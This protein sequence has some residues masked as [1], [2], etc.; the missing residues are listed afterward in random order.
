MK[1]FN[2]S[3]KLLLLWTRNHN[4]PLSYNE[5]VMAM[6]LTKKE[7]SLL[8]ETLQALQTEGLIQKKSR[9]FNLIEA[10]QAPPEPESNGK[11]NPKLLE[12]TFDA[13]PL[14]R[15]QSFAFVR[16]EKGDFFINSDDTLN[17]YHNDI[18]AIEPHYR[19][20]KADYGFVRKII[21]RKNEKVTGDIRAANGRT[22][23]ICGNPK[24]HNWFEVSEAGSANEGDKVVLAVTNWGNP[25]LGKMPSGK[26]IEV[27]GPSGDPQVELLAVLHQY[28]LPL[29]FPDEVLAEAESVVA[30]ISERDIASR[31]DYR[32]LFTFTIDPSSAKDFDDAISLEKTAKGWRLYVHIADVSHY[33]RPGS[34]MFAEAAKRGNS[35]Y[36]PKKVIPMLPEILSNKVCSLRPGEDKLTLTVVTE[37]DQHGSINRQWMT[38][39]V[40]KSDFRLSYDEVDDLFEGRATRFTD[41]LA[42]ILN[43][44]RILSGLLSQQRLKAG[45]IFFDLPELEYEYDNEGLVKRFTLAE[46]TESHRLIE[47]FMLVANEYTAKKL[48]AVSPTSI[49]RIHEDPDPEK[50]EKLIELLS[51][52]GISYYD[53][54]SLNSSIQ[55]LLQSLPNED[56]HAVFDRVILRSMKKAKYATQ[57]ERHFGL[58]METYTHFTSPIRRLCDLIIHCLCKTYI[59][60]SGKFNFS[61]DQ[62]TRHAR[63]ASEQELLADQAERDIERVYS[64]AYMRT[65]VGENYTGMVVSAKSGGA[66]VRLKQIPVNGMLKSAQFP[67]GHWRYYDKE[68]R[69]IN[70]KNNSYIQLLDKVSVKIMDVSDDIYLDLDDKDDT[71]SHPYT[72][73]A[74]KRQ[75]EP[76]P[77]RDNAPRRSRGNAVDV[78]RGSR[79]SGTQNKRR[80]GKK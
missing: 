23:F 12:G 34:A 27:L 36:F 58:G 19:R 52:Y 24:I 25:L 70:T 57:H 74:F 72:L 17:A 42:E 61:S 16:T 68:M 15:D 47:N 51:H 71:V 76:K 14:A 6:N 18:V 4:K 38:E 64:M 55:Y 54:G 26:V 29:V 9:K 49:Y 20:G 30:V 62:L 11:L 80:R 75:M 45:Y 67:S 5:M 13:T 43:E 44:S 73:P 50:I 40:I 66:I 41:R 8:S 22:I 33:V 39:S 1:N 3:E 10:A 37:I 69:F 63:N 32:D 56:Y 59:I 28:N 53:R 60:K 78:K 79:K 7:K 2:I 48:L 77:N 65:L 35:F 21:S 46:E 31:E